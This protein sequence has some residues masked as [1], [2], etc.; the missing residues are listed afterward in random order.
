MIEFH[1]IIINC[2]HSGNSDLQTKVRDILANPFVP[3]DFKK[4]GET[5]YYLDGAVIK[6]I[7]NLSWQSKD[8]SS[9]ALNN[10]QT[11]TLTPKEEARNDYLL[12]DKV[13]AKEILNLW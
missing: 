7:S 13:K 8:V 1:W 4:H 12:L 3:A 5:M 10:I 6:T 11:N 9:S 2:I